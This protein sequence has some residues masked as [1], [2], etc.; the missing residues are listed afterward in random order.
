MPA[1]R[2]VSIDIAITRVPIAW[3]AMASGIVLMP[4]ALAPIFWS[5][6]TSAGVSYDGPM[7]AA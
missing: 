1:A 4:T 2:F 7:H 5:I 3:A 6:A